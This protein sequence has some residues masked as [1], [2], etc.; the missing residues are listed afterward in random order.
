[1]VYLINTGDTLGYSIFGLN[2]ITGDFFV[3]LLILFILLL[4][5]CLMFKIPLEFIGI[6]LLPL[7][8]GFSIA[9]SNFLPVLV[10]TLIFLGIVL[11]QNFIFRQ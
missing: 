3:S 4:V 7:G 9:T 10:V 6:F 1:M 8:I 11:A 2:S 5:T